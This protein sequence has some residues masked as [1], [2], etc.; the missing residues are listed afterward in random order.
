MKHKILLRTL[1]IFILTIV[2]IAS[3]RFIK[4]PVAMPPIVSIG[5]EATLI[6]QPGD[7]EALKKITAALEPLGADAKTLSYSSDHYVRDASSVYWVFAKVHK[8]EGADP[9]S[10][11]VFKEYGD[12]LARDRT[13][14]YMTSNVAPNAHPDTFTAVSAPDGPNNGYF[15]DD[16]TVF[17]KELVSNVGDY[18]YRL[19]EIPDADPR[20]I[21]SLNKL[22]TDTLAADDKHVYVRGE[23]VSGLDGKTFSAVSEPYFTDINGTYFFSRITQGDILFL[24]PTSKTRVLTNNY[25]SGGYVITGNQVI[26]G[27]TT[28]NNANANT[29]HIL[30]S[31]IKNSSTSNR[32]PCTGSCFYAADKDAVYYK[33]QKIAGADPKTFDLIGYG[34]LHGLGKDPG[35]A[36]PVYGRDSRHVYYLGEEVVGAD[37]KTFTPIISG[38]YYYEYGKD[39]FAVYWKSKR[40]EYADPKTFRPLG[41]QQPYEGCGT[42]RYGVDATSAYYQNMR[43]EGADV[44]TFKVLSGDGSYAEDAQNFYKGFQPADKKEFRDCEY[45]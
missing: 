1:S 13:H 12:I 25:L 4:K 15:K 18:S 33:T 14:V 44:K 26:L 5:A 45:G 11:S 32:G 42:G 40:I 37:P 43:I 29:F 41:G 10:F 39:D 24:A 31:E 22:S 27:T 8:I 9:L 2:I 19:R 20:T 21:R 35:D 23:P 38:G 36:Q 30:D 7:P 34:L 28:I 16:E 3:T 6:I 17:Y